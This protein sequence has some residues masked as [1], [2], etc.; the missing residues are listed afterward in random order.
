MSHVLVTGATGFVGRQIVRRLI[1]DGR[2]VS[3]VLRRASAGRRGAL[4]DGAAIVETEDLFREDEGWWAGIL[5]GVDTLVHAAWYVEPGKYL[6]AAENLQCA[7][8]AFAMARGAANAGVTHLV[9]LGTC[10]EYRLPNASIGADAPVGPTTLYAAAK[11]SVFQVL[12]QYLPRRGIA[13]SWCRLFYLYGEGEHP[14]RLVPYVRARLDA[15]ETARLSAGTQ[16]RDFLDVADAGALIAEVVATR[17]TGVV[18][19]CSGRAVTIRDFVT[20][21]A[22]DLGREDLLEF[23]TATLHPSDPAAVVGRCNVERRAR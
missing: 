3:V 16:L 22:R 2:R 19:I 23:G 10:F 11:L 7:A 5:S 17:Q 6:D 20:A 21:I 13:F 8:S 4:P 12:E 1:A 15:G 18:N 14:A 9:G